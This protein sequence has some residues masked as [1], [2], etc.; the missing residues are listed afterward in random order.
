MPQV[1][2]A[3]KKKAKGDT[4]RINDVIAF[5]ITAGDSNNNPAERACAPQELLKKGSELKPDYEWYLLKQIFPPIERL[6]GPI[7]GTD[8]M[9]LAECLGLDTRKYQIANLV[10]QASKDIVPLDSTISDEER[11]KDAARL[12]LI[13]QACGKGFAMEG[14]VTPQVCSA[15]G[16][17]CSCGNVLPPL[18]VNL[19]LESQIRMQ[20]DQYYESWLQCDDPE[21]G[22]KTRQ[23]SVYG[24]RC[25]GRD[26][27]ARGCLGR[28]SFVYTDKALY[29]QLLYYDSLFC[30][31]KAIAKASDADKVA[32]SVLGAQNR[33]C[34]DA[35]RS[36][37][38]KYLEKCGRRYV[39]MNNIFSFMA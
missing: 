32:I 24:R 28:M 38:G 26:G 2:V 12:T 20:V 30:T 7:E 1:Q 33:Q 25:I 5:I 16:I 8:A 15:H 18:S 29:N 13:C 19:Q 22:T 14:L 23:M 36:V 27:L 31:D 35:S 34:F 9:R 3:L 11:F 21:C 10:T 39:D 4:V 6:C 37:V 17:L